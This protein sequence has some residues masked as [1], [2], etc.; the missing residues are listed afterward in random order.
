MMLSF[1]EQNGTVVCKEL[2]GLADEKIRREY[3]DCVRD[4]ARLMEAEIE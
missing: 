2:K 4:A 3:I 1:M